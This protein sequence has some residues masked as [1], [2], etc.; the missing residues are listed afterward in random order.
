MCTSQKATNMTSAWIIFWQRASLLGARSNPC[1]ARQFRLDLQLLSGQCIKQQLTTYPSS[2]HHCPSELSGVSAL[3]PVKAKYAMVSLVPMQ[4]LYENQIDLILWNLCFCAQFCLITQNDF[5][6]MDDKVEFF[7]S[8]LAFCS[9]K[10]LLY[11][12][13]WHTSGHSYRN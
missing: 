11:S 6:S 13:E 4:L 1:L 7:C 12:A 9:L 5:H 2:W 8:I 10:A 3:K